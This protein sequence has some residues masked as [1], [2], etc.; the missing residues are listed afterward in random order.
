MA[1]IIRDANGQPYCAI[2]GQD[3]PCDH[4]AIKPPAA[5]PAPAYTDAERAAMDQI[6]PFIM[7]FQRQG[8][9]L[10]YY[11]WSGQEC[12]ETYALADAEHLARRFA[13]EHQQV[14]VRDSSPF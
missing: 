7:W 6:A 12:L 3:W 5:A 14:V 11:S 10:G 4:A 13:N 9:R 2:C 8:G 1:G